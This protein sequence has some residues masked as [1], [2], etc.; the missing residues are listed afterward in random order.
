MWIESRAARRV[1]L[2]GATA[3]LSLTDDRGVRLSDH[4][5]F[6]RRGHLWI[7][8]EGRTRSHVPARLTPGQARELRDALNLFLEDHDPDL[9]PDLD[10]EPDRKS[11]RKG[12]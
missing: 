4:E 6:E 1:M 11:T 9:D 12:P 5:C 3:Y 8:G 2:S 10:L 7:S